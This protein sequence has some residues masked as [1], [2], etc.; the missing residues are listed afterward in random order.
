V[1]KQAALLI[2]IE[3]TPYVLGLIRQIAE[4]SKAPVEV[5]FIG[6]NMSQPWNLSLRGISASYLPHTTI[7]AALEIFRKLSAGQYSLLHLAGWAHWTLLLALLLAWYHRIP[8]FIES[9]T[10]LA[11]GLPLWKRV[12]KRLFYPLLFRIPTRVLPGGSR[13][14]AYFRHYGVQS[15]RIVKVQMTVDVADIMRRSNIISEQKARP[16]LRKEFGFSESQTVF[17]YVGR[18]E[19]HKG[20]EIML[21]AFDELS[22]THPGAALLV[23][24]EGPERKRVAAAARVNESIHYVGRLDYDHVIRAYNCADVAVVPSIFEPW[25]LVVNE[26]MAVGLPSVASDRVGCVDDLVKHGETGVIFS[27]GSRQ[28]LKDSMQFLVEHSEKRKTMG[29]QAQQLIAGW[30]LENW[31]RNTVDAWSRGERA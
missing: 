15:D 8:V 21:D 28:R 18:L 23:V 19:P 24:G 2:Y 7:A 1:Q 12:F 11:I 30:T 6:A 26:A 20:I 14:A 27:A 3:P 4:C 22:R 9:D 16:R 10:Q 17:I 29:N 13:Q 31:A 5:L 25:G